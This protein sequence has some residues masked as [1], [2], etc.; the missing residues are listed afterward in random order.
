MLEYF[1]LSILLLSEILFIKGGQGGVSFFFV[2]ALPLLLLWLFVSRR[3][4]WSRLAA[5]TYAFFGILSTYVIVGAF[6]YDRPTMLA[7]LVIYLISPLL[8]I[9][10]GAYGKERLWGGCL[11]LALV[12]SVGLAIAQFSY[13]TFGMVGPAGLFQRIAE[14]IYANQSDLGLENIYGRAT[15]FFTNPNTLGLFGGVSF[16]IAVLLRDSLSRLRFAVLCLLAILCILFSMSRGSLVGFLASFLAYSLIEIMSGRLVLRGR[17]FVALGLVAITVGVVLFSGVLSVGQFDRFDELFALA[18]GGGVKSSENL[19]GRVQAW[20]S[21]VGRLND[22]PFGT[23]LPPQLVIDESPDNQFIY[24]L[25]Q[26][27]YVLFLFVV[28]YYAVALFFTRPTRS[29]SRSVLFSATIFAIINSLTMVVMNSFVFS[30]F[31]LLLGA[32]IARLRWRH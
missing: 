8:F 19:G 16:W 5:T 14:S 1:T 4:L 23:I 7:Q 10:V 30:L 26:G 12:V 13:S 18:Q 24:F 2:L 6:L 15:G 25:A 28:I 21:I 31:W 11:Y 32:A 20:Q 3:F 17:F 9:Q 27:G 29:R 22:Y